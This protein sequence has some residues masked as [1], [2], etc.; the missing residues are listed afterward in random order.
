MNGIAVKVKLLPMTITYFQ[1]CFKPISSITYIDYTNFCDQDVSDSVFFGN[2][3][4]KLIDQHSLLTGSLH[5]WIMSDCLARFESFKKI[6]NVND[7]VML[8]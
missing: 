7:E 6:G 3:L 5:C 8:C 2:T 4:T 1:F